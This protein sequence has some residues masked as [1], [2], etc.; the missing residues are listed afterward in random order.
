MVSHAEILEW[1]EKQCK[2][3]AA[4]CGIDPI[5]AIQPGG[6]PWIEDQNFIF[7]AKELMRQYKSRLIY[8][9]HPRISNGKLTPTLS[10]MAG[11]AAYPR[12]SDSVL[13]LAREEDG[14]ATSSVIRNGQKGMG[15]YNRTIRIA[16][17]RNGSGAGFSIGYFFE[18]ESL[19]FREVG[20]IIPEA[21]KSRKRKEVREEDW[22][23]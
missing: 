17:A 11:G 5:T 6:K 7:A 9:I 4:V 23:D 13:W 1:L 18:P 16:K 10:S 19:C 2:Q 21:S 15:T 14:L 22:N 8:V 12:F 3:G 20:I